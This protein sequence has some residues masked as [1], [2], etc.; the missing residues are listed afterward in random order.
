VA[1]EPGFADLWPAVSKTYA[2]GVINY[3][4]YDDVAR[5][6]ATLR[7][8]T[9]AP[10]EILVVD[11]DPPSSG[12]RALRDQPGIRW[13]EMANKGFAGG[14]NRALD[15]L[16]ARATTDF[17]LLLNPDVVLEPDFAE[18]LV[19]AMAERERVAVAS[20]KL[21][22]P[23]GS[24]DSAGIWMP[25]NRRPRDRG[26][27]EVDR[28]QYDRTE[29]VF[30]ASGAAMMIRTAALPE[31]AIEGEVFDEDFFLYHE[32]TDLCWRAQLLGWEVLYVPR[33]RAQHE[34][35]WR[36]SRRFEIEASVRR[37][38]FKN[39]YLQIIKNERPR[40]FLRNLPALATWEVLRLGFALARDREILT[41]YGDALRL[42][43]RAWHKRKLVQS[44]TRRATPERPTPR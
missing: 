8:Q 35:S 29:V 33:A 2:A 7:D 3:R 16:G 11:V 14:A 6:L 40:D 42:A 5:C 30:G 4:S 13:E 32:D 1:R 37:H 17:A 28:G 9:L 18:R 26:S 38:S 22:R 39:H 23:D 19:E 12:P 41:G 10:S 24:I 15:V 20:G 44:A 21:L 27:E 25:R 36:R 43:G 31:L 34:R